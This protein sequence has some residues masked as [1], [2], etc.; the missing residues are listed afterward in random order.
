[1]WPGSSSMIVCQSIGMRYI[2]TS[3]R[4]RNAFT[5]IARVISNSLEESKGYRTVY[6]KIVLEPLE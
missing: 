4:S 3:T 1:M 2:E 5:S 6:H